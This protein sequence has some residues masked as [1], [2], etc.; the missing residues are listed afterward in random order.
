[1]AFVKLGR[2]KKPE[3]NEPDPDA[4]YEEDLGDEMEIE[5]GEWDDSDYEE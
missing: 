2:E 3:A 1:M 4:D 5:Q